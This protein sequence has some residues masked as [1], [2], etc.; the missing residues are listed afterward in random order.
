MNS[1]MLVM[2]SLTISSI[3]AERTGIHLGDHD[4]LSVVDHR[5]AFGGGQPVVDR[6]PQIAG[7]AVAGRS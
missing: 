3:L 4:V 2:P 7:Q 6:G 1:L 5:L